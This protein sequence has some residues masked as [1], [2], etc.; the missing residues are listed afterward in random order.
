MPCVVNLSMGFNGGG[1]D[2]DMVIEWIIDALVRKSGRAVVI[3]AGNENGEDKGIYYGGIVPQGQSTRIEWQN[4]L[5]LA[6][7]H[8]VLARADPSPNEMEIWYSLQSS[9]RVRLL[10]LEKTNSAN[11]CTLGQRSSANSRAGN[12]PS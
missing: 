7:S 10:T 2:G 11:G 8:G 12:T 5:L 1:H 4:G 3:A 6:T 9:L